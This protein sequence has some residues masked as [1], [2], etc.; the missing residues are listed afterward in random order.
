MR[1]QDGETLV[2]GGLISKEEEKQFAKIPFLG[3]I[4]ILG[5][6]F[7]NRSSRTSNEEI[8]IFIKAQILQ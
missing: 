6:L 1:L 5:Q 4:P 8:M 3:D 7:Q 2:I